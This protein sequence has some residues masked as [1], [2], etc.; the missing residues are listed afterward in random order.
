MD[1]CEGL[2]FWSMLLEVDVDGGA[3][4]GNEAVWEIALA[5]KILSG[6]F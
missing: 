3:A 6:V 1:A 5:A 4:K 2:M